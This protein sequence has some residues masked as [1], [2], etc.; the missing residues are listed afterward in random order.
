MA[1]ENGEILIEDDVL[2]GPGVHF[3]VANHEF[4]NREL[5]IYYQGHMEEKTIRVRKG[6]WIGAN[7]I[8]LPGVTIGKNAVAAGGAIVT[9]DVE[10]FTVVGGNPAKKIKDI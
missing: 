7:A 4:N 3:Y 9:K 1:S 2:I 8:I 5:P 10:P 6:S